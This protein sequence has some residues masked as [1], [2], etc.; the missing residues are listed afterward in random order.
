LRLSNDI[1]EIDDWIKKE[2]DQVENQFRG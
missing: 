1:S 2:Y